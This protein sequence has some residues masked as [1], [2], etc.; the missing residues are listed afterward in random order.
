[1]KLTTQ[2]INVILAVLL[3]IALFVTV[4][5]LSQVRSLQ[6]EARGKAIYT[7]SVSP[8]P[9]PYQTSFT[10]SGTGYKANS[11][12]AVGILGILCCGTV[13]TDASGSFSLTTNGRITNPDSYLLPDNYFVSV[14]RLRGKNW[15]PAASTTFTV[16]P[17]NPCQ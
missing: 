15:T 1:M 4:Y 12:V 17:T 5:A 14:A 16:C 2:T 9:V 11:T 3:L 13:S 6:T 8:N 7:V 10:I